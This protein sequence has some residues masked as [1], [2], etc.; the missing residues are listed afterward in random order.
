MELRRIGSCRL[1][2]HPTILGTIVFVVLS[3]VF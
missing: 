1:G 3:D 2:V